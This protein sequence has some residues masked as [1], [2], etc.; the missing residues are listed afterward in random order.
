MHR[1]KRAETQKAKTGSKQTPKKLYWILQ[2]LVV[3][4][5]ARQIW[6][7][8]WSNVFTCV[9]TL[10]LFLVPSIAEWRLKID[11][12]NLLEAIILIFIFA[13]EILGEIGEFYVNVPHWDSIMHT[14][15]GFMMAAIGFALIDVLNR[16]PRFHI[17]LSPLFVAFVAF[18]FSMTI[19]VLWEF[20]EYGV[21]TLLSKDMQKDTIVTAISS[22]KLHPE[23]RNI[24]VVVKGITDTVIHA[25]S[26]DVTVQ[27]GYL[28]IGLMD[29]MKDL[30]VN[31][32]GAVVFSVIGYFYIKGRSKFPAKFIPR[33]L[34]EEEVQ[35]SDAELRQRVEQLR[36]ARAE[37]RSK[38]QAK[39]AAKDS[40]Q[41]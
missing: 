12:P 33:M 40:R 38:R 7:E 31:F 21:D 34:T 8:N 1:E 9:L 22:V 13:A 27:G 17:S 14:V 23:G 32:V 25:A 36:L 3:L 15:N 28:D 30:L 10:V 19:G 29:T 35:D 41:K 2:A 20:F 39:R 16:H 6:L 18:C 11:L 24:P 5:M 4:V 37:K 26:G